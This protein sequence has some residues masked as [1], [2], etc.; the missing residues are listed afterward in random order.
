MGATSRTETFLHRG[1]LIPVSVRRP[2]GR[3]PWPTTS[4]YP[5]EEL[6]AVVEGRLGDARAVIRG[7]AATDPL[8]ADSMLLHRGRDPSQFDQQLWRR[9]PPSLTQ[10]LR[11]RVSSAVRAVADSWWQFANEET[12]TG[13][14][15][16]RL[17]GKATAEGG[18]RAEIEF[19]EFSKQRKEPETGADLALLLD[20]L[21]RDGRR[22]IKTIWLQ[23]KRETG[24][25]KDWRDLPRLRDQMAKMQKF[26][27][28]SFG[29]VYTPSGAHVVG[30]SVP[31]HPS[32]LEGLIDAGLKC[33]VGDHQ[34]R[35]YA[36]SLNRLST[37]TI[38]V[39]QI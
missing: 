19:V 6:V 26:T 8:V 24:L 5:V 33:V 3:G 17:S 4:V 22:A 21:G 27:K 7:D 13:A 34:T 15:F 10:E 9:I 37:G 39:T 31:P 12:C 23:A 28:A 16:S 29:L 2:A 32:S 11:S 1:R 38:F 35:L 36:Q 18:W 30:P 25:P 20:V 14:V